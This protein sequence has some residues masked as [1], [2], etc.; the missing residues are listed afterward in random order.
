M[1]GLSEKNA[2]VT[3]ASFGIGHAT[4]KRLAEE[5]CNL[6][7]IARTQSRLYELCQ[8][9][10]G[11][12]AVVDFAPADFTKSDDIEN[13]ADIAIGFFSELGGIHILV[14][15]AGTYEGK[16]FLELDTESW[17]YML[18]LK[19][20]SM[21]QISRIIGNDMVVSNRKGCSIVNMSSTNG[22][23]G[24]TDGAHYNAANGGAI[25]L[26]KTMAIELGKHGIRVNAV[27]PGMIRTRI[28]K[29]VWDNPDI[30]NVWKKKLLLGRIGKPEEVA[31]AI[32]FLASEEASFI[33]GECLVIDGGQLSH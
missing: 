13:A 21:F 32:A 29:P 27:C 24:E 10:R 33:T 4:V 6:F 1:R 12:G 3:G 30:L 5:G 15:N 8:E 18:N 7:I 23:I 16:P 25:T 14:N 9:L 11:D 2:V 22:L 20:R 28:T 31:A 26:T 19:L 17:D